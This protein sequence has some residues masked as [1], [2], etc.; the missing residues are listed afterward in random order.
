MKTRLLKALATTALTLSVSALAGCA[1]A[2][3]SNI[4]RTQVEAIIKDYLMKNPELVR[5]ALLELDAKKDREAI[6]AVYTAIEK[7]GLGVS[8][9]PKDAKVTVIEF[10]DYNCGFCKRSTSWIGDVL[11][12][13]PNDVR[14]VFK[15][16]PILD[17]RTGTSRLAAKAALAADKQGKYREMHFALME[18]TAISEDRIQAT[19]KS[20]GL[21]LK[22]FEKDRKAPELDEE[23]EKTLILANRI[24]ALTGTPFFI[25]NDDFM[26]GADTGR[27]QA[28][29]DEALE[30]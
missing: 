10:F 25:I 29:L 19:A 15:E 6:A 5:D 26:P 13:H 20:I 11:E 23:L 4:E 17:G 12:A 16:L 30:G 28:M 18:S 8:V 14:V 27:L 9:G 24:P 22:K 21:D 1:Q 2:Q 7:D 3:P